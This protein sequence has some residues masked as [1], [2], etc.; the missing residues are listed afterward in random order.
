MAERQIRIVNRLGIHARSAKKL[1]DVAQGFASE[2]ALIKE[3]QTANGKRIMAVLTLY[4]PQGTELLVRTTG[5]D[6][7][8]ALEAIG[9]LVADR[10][11]EPD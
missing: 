11:G 7:E 5:D 8:E 6:A 2:V 9:T 1:V 4:A 10:F 3:G